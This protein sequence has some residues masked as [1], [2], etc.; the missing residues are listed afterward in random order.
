MDLW[1]QGDCVEFIG[2][3]HMPQSQILFDN[4]QGEIDQGA[5]WAG[6]RLV[7]NLFL[8]NGLFEFLFLNF[9]VVLGFQVKKIS[10][11]NTK[12]SVVILERSF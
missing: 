8:F 2:D 4:K 9:T 1:P 6:R 5:Q 3:Y 10:L 12:V 7:F 11:Q